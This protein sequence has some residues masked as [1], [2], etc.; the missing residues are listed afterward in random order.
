MMRLRMHQVFLPAISAYLL[1]DNMKTWKTINI[2]RKEYQK[3]VD[4]WL[5]TDQEQITIRVEQGPF[6][7]VPWRREKL[8]E[9]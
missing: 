4:L 1:K 8:C 6:K 2:K 5:L 3:R 7:I 9:C